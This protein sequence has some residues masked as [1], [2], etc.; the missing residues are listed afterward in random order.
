MKIQI[1]KAKTL[2]SVDGLSMETRVGRVV[3][4][5][6]VVAVATYAM[7]SPS[8]EICMAVDGLWRGLSL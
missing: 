1:V 2:A 7:A 8:T 6:N 4:A 3:C 5:K